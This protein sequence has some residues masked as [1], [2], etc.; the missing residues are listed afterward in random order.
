MKLVTLQPVEGAQKKVDIKVGKTIIG[1]GP[2]LECADKKVSR[3]HA[4]LEVQENGDV[5]L[6]P[7]HVNPCFFLPNDSKGGFEVLKKDCPQRIRDGDSFSLLPNSFRYRVIISDVA[8]YESG[9]KDDTAGAKKDSTATGQGTSGAGPGGVGGGKK[10]SGPHSAEPTLLNGEKKDRERGERDRDKETHGDQRAGGGH[11]LTP[12]PL[13]DPS[14]TTTATHSQPKDNG[15]PVPLKNGL[16]PA[17][18][19]RSEKFAPEKEKDFAKEHSP[20]LRGSHALKKSHLLNHIDHGRASTCDVTPS[21]KAAD[22]PNNLGAKPIGLSREPAKD[23]K[24]GSDQQPSRG[25]K[26]LANDRGEESVPATKKILSDKSASGKKDATGL[27]SGRK[28]PSTAKEASTRRRS[29][30]PP[31]T[32]TGETG[33]V[34]SG[35]NTPTSAGAGGTSGTATGGQSRSTRTN[36]TLIQRISLDDFM[37]SDD[38]WI[39]T[40]ASSDDERKKA[41]KRQHHSKRKSTATG[42]ESDSDSDDWEGISSRKTA[43]KRPA[44]RTSKKNEADSHAEDG[45]DDEQSPARKKGRGRVSGSGRKTAKKSVAVGSDD[46]NPDSE[47]EEQPRRDSK[48]KKLSR[49]KK[50][51]KSGNE[52]QGMGRIKFYRLLLRNKGRLPSWNRTITFAPVLSEQHIVGTVNS[53]TRR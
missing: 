50:N 53:S 42:A 19:R 36:R 32:T 49:G 48:G 14:A 10:D 2:L 35:V 3:N 29:P 46:D 44:K 47:Q 24:S 25:S 52:P 9:D 31:T 43:K 6:T 41:K 30:H 20:M 8:D 27:G 23:R 45:S 17:R 28:G 16:S 1:R 18:S 38:E 26:G 39:A 51:A 37:A 11:E 7:T 21:D 33:G 12:G 15:K 34:A 4:L 5:F 13:H 40:Y 22:G